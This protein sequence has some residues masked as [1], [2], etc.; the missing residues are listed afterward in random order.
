MERSL[1]HIEKI[2]W[3]RPIE[4]ADKIELLGVLGWQC[5]SAKDNGFKVGDTVIYI[6]VD[7]IMPDKP[8]F[9]FL[10][11]RKFKIKTIKL[12]GEYS[13]GLILPLS[14]L[15][16]NTNVKIGMDVTELLG[17]TQNLSE[18]ETIERDEIAAIMA[19]SNA[20]TKYMMRYAWFRK[21]KQA[22]NK[23][24][25]WPSWVTKTDET[26]VQNMPSIIERLADEDVYITEKIDYQS[27][28]FT[29]KPV[30]QRFGWKFLNN[31]FCKPSFYVCTRNSV[32]S[33]KSGLYWQIAR[34]Y[35]LEQICKENPGII[36]QG[37]Q[38]NNRVQGNKYGL[39]EPRLFVFT[40]K[41]SV[42]NKVYDY[43]EMKAFCDKNGLETVPLLYQGKLKDI[44][45]TVDDF[46]NYSM[47]KSKIANIER[48]G[49]V[50]R[51][52]KN[53]CKMASF[54]VINPK[55]LLKNDL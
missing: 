5:V 26:R 45:T 3:I 31:L 7:S 43:D 21:V 6:E 27:V 30:K 38:G 25:K 55:F 39:K 12:R 9:E 24:S 33:N 47:G 23:D 37:E 41:D 13:Q 11:E 15:P 40:I 17:I 36:I 20:F 52:I 53:G 18:D 16:A 19:N 2:E 49:V 34:K 48:E 50:I 8:E 51:C 10:R 14:V 1:A 44:G 22:T 28:T 32:T 4:G 29:S 54:K 35:N 46:V 42:K